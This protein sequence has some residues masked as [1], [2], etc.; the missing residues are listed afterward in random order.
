MVHG[1]FEGCRDRAEL[2]LAILRDRSDACGKATGQARQHHLDWRRPVVLRRE[3]LGMVC[4]ERELAAVLLL[5]A[6]PEEPFHGGLAVRAFHPLILGPPR[7]L[8]RLGG[9]G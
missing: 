2:D 6:E 5:L 7:E 3:N 1:T 8:C 4:L 9:L